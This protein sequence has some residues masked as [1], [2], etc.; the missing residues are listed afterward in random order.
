MTDARMPKVM[1]NRRK[2]AGG[3]RRGE[4]GGGGGGRV[5]GWEGRRVEGGEVGRGREGRGR[6]GVRI[7]QIQD[8]FVIETISEPLVAQRA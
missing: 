7:I 1:Q 4:V 6:G 2:Y 3:G 8:W 5:G